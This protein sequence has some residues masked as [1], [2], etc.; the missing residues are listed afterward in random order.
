MDMNF[1]LMALEEFYFIL[2]SILCW[3]LSP[4]EEIKMCIMTR[5]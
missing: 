2:L 4:Y 1:E 3:Q 5:V